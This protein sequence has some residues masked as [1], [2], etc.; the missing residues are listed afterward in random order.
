M[1]SAEKRALKRIGRSIV[2]ITIEELIRLVTRTPWTLFLIPA[3]Q[4]L[5]KWLR[6]RWGVKHVPI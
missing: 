2:V 3:L 5:G 1:G 6:D 4:G